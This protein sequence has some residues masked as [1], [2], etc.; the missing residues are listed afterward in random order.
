MSKKITDNDIKKL[1]EE[2]L[3]EQRL[4]EKFEFPDLKAADKIYKHSLGNP[5]DRI[6]KSEEI[7]GLLDILALIADPNTTLDKADIEYF[8]NVPEEQKLE[9]YEKFNTDV[10]RAMYLIRALPG[11]YAG[12]AAGDFS[13]GIELG[14]LQRLFLS[15]QGRFKA[16]TNDRTLKTFL[17]ALKKINKSENLQV[18]DHKLIKWDNKGVQL[19][20]LPDIFKKLKSTNPEPEKLSI[21]T[22]TDPKTN[23]AEEDVIADIKTILGAFGNYP[24]MVENAKL[25]KIAIDS[26]YE[27]QRD[28]AGNVDQTLTEPK[29]DS[30]GAEK[31]V[32]PQSQ[33]EM[34]KKLLTAGSFPERMAQVNEISKKYKAASAADSEEE[35]QGI[36]GTDPSTILTE[37]MLLD[38]FNSLLRATTV[39]Q[40]RYGFEALLALIAGGSQEGATRTSSGTQGVVDFVDDQGRAGSAKLYKSGSGTI[41]QSLANF[42][43]ARTLSG[44]KDYQVHYVIGLKKQ[45]EEQLGTD[46]LSRGSGEATKTVVLEIHEPILGLDEKGFYVIPS[47]GNEK[48]RE[49]T[50]NIVSGGRLNLHTSLPLGTSTG[51]IYVTS[52]RVQTF[53]EYVGKTMEQLGGDAKLMFDY[54][55]AFI[56]SIEETKEKSKTYVSSTKPDDAAATLKSLEDSKTNFNGVK[57]IMDNF[58]N[59]GTGDASPDVQSESID[60]K[61][62]KPIK[63]S[64]ITANFLKK[65]ISET[66]K[67]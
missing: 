40:A 36:I 9:R 2:V 20:D 45:G 44:K 17:N 33:I 61:N 13:A 11:M 22:K 30:A 24:N 56:K 5:E 38:L 39:E 7:R 37:I 52:S 10:E 14:L 49:P 55:T 4:N 47:G 28:N 19:A 60:Q 62:R 67:K 1:I 65:I 23:Y 58:Y 48:L 42:E 46:N 18:G 54:F 8:I 27:F 57:E 63:E 35:I 34:V 29:I 43:E 59:G 66:F 21:V 16:F 31:G 64:K 26:F 50:I 15:G 3:Q 32:F 6:Q 41:D 25:A 53:R 51:E 12:E